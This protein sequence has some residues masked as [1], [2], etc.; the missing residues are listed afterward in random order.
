MGPG[1]FVDGQNQQSRGRCNRKDTL[2]FLVLGD[3]SFY[4]T[5]VWIFVAKQGE[6][7]LVAMQVSA[8]APALWMLVTATLT[9]TVASHRCLRSDLHMLTAQRQCIIWLRHGLPLANL[10]ATADLMCCGGCI[11]IICRKPNIC[12]I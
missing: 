5:H 9:Y 1:G 6:L 10:N 8:T 11:M 4:Y 3:T 2:N 12:T 7:T